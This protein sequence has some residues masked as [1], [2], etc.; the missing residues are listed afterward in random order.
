MGSVGAINID[1]DC[2]RLISFSPIYMQLF[3][4]QEFNAIRNFK[5]QK[6]GQCV[7]LEPWDE[8]YYTAMMK[9]SIYDLDSSVSNTVLSIF[10]CMYT[11]QSLLW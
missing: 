4:S 6:S 9:S 8:A 2:T 10:W 11:D 3:L 1:I 7:D 5:R